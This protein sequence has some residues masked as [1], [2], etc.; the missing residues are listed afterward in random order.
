[1]FRAQAQQAL[2]SRPS[3]LDI[4]IWEGGQRSSTA[5]SI[6]GQS[7]AVLVIA[8]ATGFFITQPKLLLGRPSLE[9]GK[10]EAT[11]MQQTEL[12]EFCKLNRIKLN[13]AELNAGLRA[14]AG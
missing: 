10:A 11:W 9:S 2:F 7:R 3:A 8:G 5:N 13:L 4:A 1:M 14:F 6:Q 12:Q